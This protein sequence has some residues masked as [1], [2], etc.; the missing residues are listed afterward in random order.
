L[1]LS[2][3][4]FLLCCIAILLWRLWPFSA[5]RTAPRAPQLSPVDPRLT[6]P[7]PYRNVRPEVRY[8]GD[9]VCA[10]C[11][12]D[13][14]ET[15]RRHPMGRSLAP[16]AQADP[17]ERYDQAAG[18]PFEKEGF[19]FLV[20]RRD[21]RVFHKE[22]Y[23][24][25]QNGAT[26][27]L[28]TEEVH[29]AVGSGRRGRT[30]LINHDGYL[31]QSPL[32]WYSEPGIWDLTPGVQVREQFERPA[33]PSCLFCHCNQV[34]PVADTVNRYRSPIFRGHA[35]GCERCHG[36]GELH[37]QPPSPE[38]GKDS[39]MNEKG[40]IVNPGRLAPALR[41]AVCQ[42]CHLQGEIRVVRRGRE[43]FD[44]RPGLPLHLFLS[45]FVRSEEFADGQES[46]SHTEQI[47]GSRCFRASQ[48]KLGCI[49]CHDPHALPGA[50]QKVAYFRKRCLNCHTEQSCALSSPVRLAKNPADDCVNCH[51]PRTGSKIVHRAITDHRIRRRPNDIIP[52]QNGPRRLLSG[53][54]PLVHFHR[55]LAGPDEDIS[56]DLGLALSEL[57]KTYPQLA[58]HVNPIALPLLEA[59]VRAAL[60]DVLAWEAKGFALWQLD[61]KPEAL[62]ALQTA[63]AQAPEREL[64]L[65]YLAVLAASIGRHEDAIAYWQRA[66]VVNPLYSQYHIRLA[67]LLADRR[68]WQKALEEARAGC[69][70]RPAAL[71][72]RLLLITC[73]IRNGQ[74]AQARAEFNKLL[75][76]R[77]DDR[78]K[79]LR[80]FGELLSGSASKSP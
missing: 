65:S 77:P 5:P 60:D 70:L 16:I 23:H 7:T 46:G 36:P 13:I 55:D 31:L 43:L 54:I 57:G 53:E 74:P 11:H 52:S 22:L 9:R 24:D 79:L 39:R 21:G 72:V 10:E 48:G 38:R 42:Q 80:W 49:S 68:E 29:F 17:V 44:Y 56:R 33:Q 34:E 75:A 45:V 67:T 47:Y 25:V 32:S 69:N 28:A 27:E 14:A 15:Y 61:R 59:A 18:N 78:E 1:T 26:L 64:T 66:I 12:G 30:Y 4:A 50:D 3:G 62:A 76:I 40:T 37:V 6:Y 51:M 35:I 2:A 58:G 71:D 19:Q 20:E 8:V 41:D 63:L 73:M